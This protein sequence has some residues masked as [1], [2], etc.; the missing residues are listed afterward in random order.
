M[1]VGI[2]R[3]RGYK[4][5]N[6]DNCIS[7]RGETLSSRDASA[8]IQLKVSRLGNAGKRGWKAEV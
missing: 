3:K 4:D 8:H 5:R 7:L 1:S 6:V 2:S